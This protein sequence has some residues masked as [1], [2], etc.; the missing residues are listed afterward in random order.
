MTPPST[1]PR[2]RLHSLDALR[3]LAAER[4]VRPV[5][6]ATRGNS[7]VSVSPAASPLR[8]AV[9]G[10]VG[11][12]SAGLAVAN[13]EV[14]SE[15][16]DR[17]H[18]IDFYGVESFVRPTE[19]FGREGFTY[20]GFRMPVAEAG[21]AHL[22]KVRF[23]RL[24][25]ILDPPYSIL[26][27]REF[28]KRI[29]RSIRRTHLDQPYDAVLFLGL[30]APIRVPGVPV[31]SWTQGTPNGELEALRSQ[32]DRIVRFCGW[33]FYTALV[34]YYRWKSQVVRREIRLSDVVIGGSR[35]AGESWHQLGLPP[36]RYAPLAYPVDVHRFCPVD[37]PVGNPIT[38][39]HLGRWVPRKRPDLLLEGFQFLRRADPNVRLRVVGA[40]AY[41]AGYRNLLKDPRLMDGVEYTPHVPRPEALEILQTADVL[42]QPSENENF[43]TAVAEAQCCG[44]PVVL[45]PTNGTQDYLGTTEFVFSAYE[46]QAVADAMLRAVR[47]VRERR[48]E[49]AAQA[50]AA[51]ERNFATPAVVDRLIDILRR[52]RAIAVKG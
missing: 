48:D 47:A 33:W 52:A 6:T 24:G 34:T 4:V 45:G 49:L 44:V 9:Y 43:G 2:E 12:D 7:F 46:P 42:V 16:L 27:Y 3:D 40:V 28:Y 19:L 20:H 22:N 36:E 11:K 31:V 50:R 39:L 23:L 15:L 21:R 32:R 29:A 30:H 14:L 13:Y 18:Q 35:W 38:L 26:M 8:L 5:S 51:A 1:L 25:T 37:R 41:G 17:G 10:F